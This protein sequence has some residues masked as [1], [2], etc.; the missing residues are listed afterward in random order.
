MAGRSPKRRRKWWRKR[1][2]FAFVKPARIYLDEYERKIILADLLAIGGSGT[3][4]D[5]ERHFPGRYDPRYFD[6]AMK[7]LSPLYVQYRGNTRLFRWKLWA[8][9]GHATVPAHEI[10]EGLELPDKRPEE[11]HLDMMK[12]PDKWPLGHVLPLAR[13]VPVDTPMP[14]QDIL[15]FNTLPGNQ[16]QEFGVLAISVE[17]PRWAVFR[18][19]VHDPRLRALFVAG[20]VADDVTVYPGYSSAEEVYADG[21]RVQ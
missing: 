15:C 7:R 17:I 2:P 11:D 21:W 10:T 12:T 8:L 5:M 18:L 20:R 19:N 4:F 6:A 1:S 16:R 13:N 3:W 14:E 9:R